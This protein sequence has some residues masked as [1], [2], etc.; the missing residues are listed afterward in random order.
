MSVSHPEL[1]R[2]R[3]SRLTCLN[4]GMRSGAI[5]GVIADSGRAGRFAADRNPGERH[6]T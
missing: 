1:V 3:F 5:P 6:G 2:N 4:G